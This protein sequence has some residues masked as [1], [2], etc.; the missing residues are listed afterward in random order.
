MT[1][2]KLIPSRFPAPPADCLMYLFGRQYPTE[3][4][5]VLSLAGRIDEGRLHDAL[6]RSLDAEPVLGCRFVDH[7]RRPYWQRRD[8]LDKAARCDVVEAAD[9]SAALARFVAARIDPRCD[10]LVQ[11][12]V[13]RGDRDT[14]CIKTAHE[15]ADGPAARDYYRLLLRLYERLRD[16]PGYRPPVNLG[17]R[18]MD[19]ISSRFTLRQKLDELRTAR[20]HRRALKERSWILPE[21]RTHDAEHGLLVMKID[22]DRAA[23]LK[24]FGRDCGAGLTS[25]ALAAFY[26]ALRAMFAPVEPQAA[27]VG[28]TVDLRRFLPPERL[29]LA[30]ANVASPLCLRLDPH[31]Q[32][33][34]EELAQCIAGQLEVLSDPAGRTAL[35]PLVM[36]YP[37]VK[38]LFTALPFAAIKRRF[39]RTAFPEGQ[40]IP[41]LFA[42]LVN[43]GRLDSIADELRE[44]AV[45]HIHTCCPPAIGATFF[46]DFSGFRGGLTLALQF[47]RRI[48]GQSAAQRL[49]EELDRTL[50]FFSGTPVTIDCL[51]AP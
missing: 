11:V 43:A 32:A 23:G 8:D 19:G 7:W 28:T 39:R 1:H 26:Q 34:L 35:L 10:P 30:V 13:F 44:V 46:L 47:S 49:L 37:L 12:R 33:T 4:H 15:A 38:F 36:L 24:R 31:R 14:L 41:A 3:L 42:Y 6:R 51:S 9:P 16:E 27:G 17:Q 29:P 20:G 50:P 21:P 40:R 5:C 22:A 18:T 2:G 48:V 25:V 45:D